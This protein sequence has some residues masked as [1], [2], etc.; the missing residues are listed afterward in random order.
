MINLNDIGELK[1]I[2][3]RGEA[4]LGSHEECLKHGRGL[5]ADALAAISLDDPA[6][7]TMSIPNSNVTL[8][9]KSSRDWAVFCAI[10]MLS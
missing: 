8:K 5:R 6:T 4:Y 3:V 1:S 10:S 9:A 7:N 2:S